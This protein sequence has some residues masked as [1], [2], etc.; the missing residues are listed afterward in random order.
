MISTGFVKILFFMQL[1]P[2]YSSL[3]SMVTSTFGSVGP[4]IRFLILW[5]IFFT[6]LYY[7]LRIE[8][9]EGDEQYNNLPPILQYFM[10]TYRD[11]IG[12]ISIPGYKGWDSKFGNETTK[13]RA[14]K[15]IIILLIWVV[16]LMNQFMCLIVLLNFLIAVISQVYDNVIAEQKQIMYINRASLNK[17][18]FQM[19]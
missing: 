3:V 6:V 17:E 11:S 19:L 2:E 7:N 8:I 18:Y 5:M 14:N 10:M 15:T 12:D 9:E 4:F 1:S 16:W 13:D